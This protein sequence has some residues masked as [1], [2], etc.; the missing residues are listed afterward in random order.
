[1]TVPYT[2]T[3]ALGAIPLAQLDANFAAVGQATNI[4]NTPAGNVSSTTVQAAINELDD[5]KVQSAT[6]AAVGGAALV[7]NTPAGNV[8]ATTVQ[9]AINELDSEKVQS[10][11]LAASGGSAL[12]GYLPS[13]TG[14]VATTTQT[15]LQQYVSVKDFGAVGDGVTDDTAAFTAALATGKEVF[16][17][18]G[19]YGVTGIVFSNGS[20]LRGEGTWSTTQQ[21]DIS[22]A[23]T[24]LKYIGAGGTNSFVVRMS[25]AAVG[26]DPNTLAA[27][28]RTLMNCSITNLVINGNDLAEYGL[29]MVRAWS[30]NKIESITVTGTVKHAFWAALCWN[31][32]PRDWFAYKNIGAGITIGANT[33]S[34]SSAT[35]DQSVCI[36]FIGSYSGYNQSLVAQNVFNETTNQ[37]KEY[38]IGVFGCRS[39]VLLEAQS[40]QNGGAGHYVS[41]TFY[42]VLFSGGYNEGNAKSTNNASGKSW[43]IWVNSTASSWAITFDH[44][45]LGLT[46]AIRLTGTAPSRSEFGVLFNRVPL[47]NEI[48]AD[49]SNFRLIDCNRAVTYTGSSPTSAIYVPSGIQ[50]DTSLAALNYYAEGTWTPTIEGATIAGTGWAYSVQTA[51]YTRIG[52][53]VFVQ[54]R[55]TLSTLSTDATGQMRIAGLPFVSKNTNNLFSAIQIQA[56]N[57]AVAVVAVMGQIVANT[58]VIPLTR[59]AAA[60][61]SDASMVLADLSATTIFT[62]SASYIAA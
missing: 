61:T 62:F 5:E 28:V 37:D 39:V 7:G 33:F 45:H 13:G 44:I 26:T 29:Y 14:A 25:K 50:F 35:V 9:A 16:V 27:A 46:P 60:S 31:G 12:V 3:N 54:G 41:T 10:T 55:V 49:W 48:F 57:L 36:N 59:R 34:W 18:A 32:S 56:N 15:K 30:N 11:T 51:A 23:T 17:P 2:F 21:T 52:R 47:M 24:V 43:D 22:T 20:R 58:S 38:G 42:P 4:T 53:Q 19:T 8:A 1:M 6:L 40:F